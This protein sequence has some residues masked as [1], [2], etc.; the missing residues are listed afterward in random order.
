MTLNTYES[1]LGGGI[2]KPAKILSVVGH[3]RES[4]RKDGING[5]GPGSNLQGVS[6]VGNTIWKREMG[7]DQVDSQGPDEVPPSGVATDYVDDG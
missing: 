5:A 4:Y 1:L 7:G 3:D 2:P 6:S